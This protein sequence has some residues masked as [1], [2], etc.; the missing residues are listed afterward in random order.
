MGSQTMGSPS[1]CRLDSESTRQ[2]SIAFLVETEPGQ[3]GNPRVGCEGGSGLLAA[4]WLAP[5]VARFLEPTVAS[6]FGKVE[7]RFYPYGR[8]Q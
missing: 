8:R 4:T 6:G 1:D 5:P 3:N 2:A 7:S